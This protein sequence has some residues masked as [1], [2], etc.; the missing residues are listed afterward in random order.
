MPAEV[1]FGIICI[2]AGVLAYVLIRLVRGIVVR[3]YS[4]TF[5]E[6]DAEKFLRLQQVGGLIVPGLIVL[7][8]VGF[9]IFGLAGGRVAGG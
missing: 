1:F 3:G 5:P 9:V 4:R 7:M 8:G 2:G 6:R